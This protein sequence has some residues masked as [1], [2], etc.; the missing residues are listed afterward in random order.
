MANL[1]IKGIEDDFYDQIKRLAKSENRSISQQVL[2]L[3]RGYLSRE[4]SIKKTRTPAQI[5]LELS[6]SWIDSKSAE[7]IV[8]EIKDNRSNSNKLSEGF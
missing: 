3:I 4:K 5:L 1:H 7:E 6:G 2:Y 8:H